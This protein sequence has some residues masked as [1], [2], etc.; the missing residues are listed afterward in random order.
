MA[1]TLRLA[2]NDAAA[3]LTTKDTS[4]QM[5]V[6][7]LISKSDVQTSVH[8]EASFVTKSPAR[9]SQVA[10][11]TRSAN[12]GVGSKKHLIKDLVTMHL[13]LPKKHEKQGV[14]S[15]VSCETSETHVCFDPKLHDWLS[16]KS[17]LK[18]DAFSHGQD[19]QAAEPSDR[20]AHILCSHL[21]FFLQGSSK[22]VFIDF[23]IG[24]F[25]ASWAP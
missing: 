16:Y 9:I 3:D 22:I 5:K 23:S 12:E 19:S 1:R 25:L 24:S 11:P 18:P 2:L 20:S 10:T 6:I 8:E 17:T 14:L 13:Q 4:G 15:L 7:P 21:L